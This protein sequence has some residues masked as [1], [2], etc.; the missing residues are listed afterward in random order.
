M[1]AALNCTV[2]ISIHAP[3]MG[4]D[5]LKPLLEAEGVVISIHA[6]RM[7]SDRA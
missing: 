1:A 4:S 2:S 3:R 7:G 5:V 6:P